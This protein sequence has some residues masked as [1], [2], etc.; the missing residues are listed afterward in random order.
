MTE[1]VKTMKLHL[2]VEKA[3]IQKLYDITSAYMDACNYVSTYIFNN[4]FCLGFMKIQD[5]IYKNI[6][7]SYGL[8]SQFAIS[9]IKTVT[10]RYKAVKEQLFQNPYRYKD[11]N[12]KWKTIQKTLEWLQKPITFHRPQ[13]DFV[14][15]R[16]Y[17]FISD[18]KTGVNYISLNSLDKKRIKATYDMPDNFEE[19]FDGSWQLGTGKLVSLNGKWYLHIPMTKVID[20]DFSAE[21]TKHLVG[22]DRGIRFLETIYDETGKT[23]FI[24][25]KEVSEKRDK[26]QQTRSELQAKGTK[27]AKRALKRISGRENRWMTDV[28][29]K[30]S[31]TLVQKYGEDTLFVIEDLS[32]VSFNEQNLS[33]LSSDDKRELRSWTFYQL[34]QFITCELPTACSR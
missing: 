29:H 33:K 16:D 8:K 9:A 4:G 34:E 20:N 17:S 11:E 15:G 25:G 14:R 13:A 10:A 1:I 3:D 21:D 18:K 5:K 23:D 7:D 27:S 19:Y 28:N 32:G 12:D 2:N 26:F 24:N 31:K 22:I 30:L 6:R